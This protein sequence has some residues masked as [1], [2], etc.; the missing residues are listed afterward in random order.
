MTSN[1]KTPLSDK[2]AYV[3]KCIPQD[4][5]VIGNTTLYDG[6]GTYI[7]LN[8]ANNTLDCTG[9]FSFYGS[10]LQYPLA[11]KK[12]LYINNL[13]S[14]HITAT[15]QIGGTSGACDRIIDGCPVISP[16]SWTAA[17]IG[18]PMYDEMSNRN[19][20]LE[21]SPY[22]TEYA[23]FSINPSWLYHGESPTEELYRIKVDAPMYAGEVRTF[24]FDVLSIIKSLQWGQLNN[25]NWSAVHIGD[26]LYFGIESWGSTFTDMYIRNIDFTYEKVS[27]SSAAMLL[28]GSVA[29][30]FLFMDNKK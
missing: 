28:I 30:G 2:W 17:L 27:S 7:Y 11:T 3:T 12:V 16:M 1:L 23:D 29:L 18:I 21:I 15:V 20:W 6:D 19:L 22:W 8:N 10:A 9:T 13:D 4:I 25:I 24:N 26:G 5:S 14:L